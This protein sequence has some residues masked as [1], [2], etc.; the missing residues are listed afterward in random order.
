[1]TFAF[2]TWLEPSAIGYAEAQ[3]GWHVVPG[4]RFTRTPG[5]VTFSTAQGLVFQ[6]N[7][8]THLG[9]CALN[10]DTT[11]QNNLIVGNVF[12]DISS[13]A[14]QIGDLLA[15][16]EP[17]HGNTVRDNYVTQAAAEYQSAVGI[18][19]AYSDHASIVHNEVANLPYTGISLGWGWGTD[20]YAKANSIAYNSIHDVMELLYDGGAIYT[21]SSQP[22]STVTGNAIQRSAPGPGRTGI[23]HDQGSEYFT[24]SSN[25]IAGF[26][27]WLQMDWNTG[28]SNT[29]ANNTVK[30][31]YADYDQVLCAGS[32]SGSSAQC[33]FSG[34]TVN[35]N[36]F[37]NGGAWPAAATS[38]MSAAGLEA[39]YQGIKSP[40][41][42]DA[43]CNGTETTSNCPKDC[44]P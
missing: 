34:N 9:G 44:A 2:A 43:T 19:F 31:N 28:K 40:I 27:Y 18:F 23:Y 42:G 41:C 24:D 25:V 8:F 20:S 4:S 30:N 29:V 22:E 36:T 32:G 26:W 6:N 17:N 1:L 35:A 3:A 12:S 37:T 13:T 5:T 38:I 21:L 16:S 14:V 10:L 33:G 7:I 15:D 11:S 39:A